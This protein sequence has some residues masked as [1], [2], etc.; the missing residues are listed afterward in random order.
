[1]SDDEREIGCILGTADYL[2]QMSAPDY[3]EKLPILYEE[4]KEGGVPGYISAQDLM[5]KT[6]SF[7]ED[8]VMRVLSED[9]HCVYQL[10][11]S[12]FGGK[13]LYIE[14]IEKNIELLRSSLKM[15]TKRPSRSDDLGL[16]G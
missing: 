11:A 13:N 16:K 15:E 8:V 12:H 14:G 5:E 9:F 6:P 3:L 7:F 4:F 1:M 2:G 10:A